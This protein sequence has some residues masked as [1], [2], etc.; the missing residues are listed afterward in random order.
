[1]K[2]EQLEQEFLTLA[3]THQ[4]IIHKVCRMY[5]DNEMD[6]KDLFQD[7]L[8]QLWRA[9]PSFKGQSKFTT[10]AYRVAINTAISNYRKQKRRP[11]LDS[12]TGKA[13]Q[14]PDYSN[15]SIEKEEKQQLLHRAI[16]KLTKI[17]KAIIM[18]YLEEHSYEEIAAI[19]G[20]TKTNVGVKINR[21]K[22]KLKKIMVR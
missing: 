14:I 19:I 8:I 9:F 13:F 5:C 10:W 18:L 12:L 22:T 1:M 2:E 16:N 4:G 17:E 20:I 7:I 6:R 3:E 15:F 21:I 11:K